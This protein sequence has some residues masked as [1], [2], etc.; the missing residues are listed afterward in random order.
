MQRVSDG[1]T[2]IE[3]IIFLTVSAIIFAAAANLI[4][5]HQAEVEFDQTVRD[6][7][8]KVEDWINDV[9]TGFTGGDP[10]QLNC[11]TSGV[12]GRPVISTAVSAKVP[13]CIFEGKA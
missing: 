7:Q 9:S 13:D 1:Y 11:T 4:S 5:G 10:N 8:T 2:I 6:T 12:T 3:V